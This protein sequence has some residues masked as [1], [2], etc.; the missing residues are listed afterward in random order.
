MT[1]TDYVY[2]DREANID[3]LHEQLI[4]LNLPDLEGVYR[5]IDSPGPRL[6]VRCG[7]LSGAQLAALT[8]A[9]NAHDERARTAGQ[10]A[11]DA[12]RAADAAD[13]A[14][15]AAILIKADADVTAGEVKALVLRLSRRLQRMGVI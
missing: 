1:R 2:G 14:A 15:L 10:Q 8:S 6:L 9:I 13:R 12:V 7:A 5:R 3:L 11:R 4:A